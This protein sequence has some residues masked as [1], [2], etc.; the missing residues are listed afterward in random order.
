MWLEPDEEDK[1]ALPLFVLQGDVPQPPILINMS[2][3]GSP[4]HLELDTGAAVTVM[5]EQKFRQLFPDQHIE[6]PSIELT[7]HTGELM[8]IV[9]ETTMEVSFAH[10]GSK[11]LVL[12]VVAG[13]GPSLLGRNWLQHF[14]L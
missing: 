10:Q 5:S 4:V 14:V 11:S 2:L 8:N 3:N 12:V 7:T 6:Q 1:E 9:G 13:S